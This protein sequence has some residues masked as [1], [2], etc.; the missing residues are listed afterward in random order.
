MHHLHNKGHVKLNPAEHDA[1]VI[2]TEHSLEARV[3]LKERIDWIVGYVAHHTRR[4]S[5]LSVL[6]IKR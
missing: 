2:S 3:G 5:L 6:I 1:K 4:S